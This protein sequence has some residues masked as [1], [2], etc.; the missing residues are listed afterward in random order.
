MMV[1]GQRCASSDVVLLAVDIVE[2]N[3]EGVSDDHRR[4]RWQE[5]AASKHE[6][7]REHKKRDVSPAKGR[8]EL[9]MTNDWHA[10]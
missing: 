1:P 9:K 8:K 2:G 3:M 6:N 5:V 4:R 10:K 7:D